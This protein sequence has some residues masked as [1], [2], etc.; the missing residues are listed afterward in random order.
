ME[1]DGP[2]LALASA[3]PTD[4]YGL[5]LGVVAEVD[6]FYTELDRLG[7]TEAHAEL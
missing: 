6:V 1:G 2:P 5:L 4:R 3:L 7:D